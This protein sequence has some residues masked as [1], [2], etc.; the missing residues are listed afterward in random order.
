MSALSE[1]ERVS[2]AAD[3]SLS[4]SDQSAS[5]AVSGADTGSVSRTSDGG[6]ALTFSSF[7]TLTGSS[8]ADDFDI[9]GTLSGS[10]EG[11]AGGMFRVLR[12][13]G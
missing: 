6:Q 13:G 1:I 3:S 4:V 5:F 7:G 12:P 9:T 2:G 10:V 11:G 8:Q